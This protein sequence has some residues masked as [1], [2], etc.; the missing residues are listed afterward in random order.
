MRVPQ[1]MGLERFSHVMH[2]TSIVEGQAGRRS[3]S[4]RRARVVLPGGHR[5]G[6]AEGARDADHPRAR[7]DAARALRRRG[8]LSRLRRQPRFLHRDPHGHHV[9]AARRYVQAG[10]G[11][12]IDSNP[13]AEYEET[14]DK[15]RALLRALEL[16]QQGYKIA[17]FRLLSPGDWRTAPGPAIPFDRQSNRPFNRLFN[18]QSNLQYT[19]ISSL[20]NLKFPYNPSG[21]QSTTRSPTTSSSTSAELPAGPTG[22]GGVGTPLALGFP[23]Q[24][25][26]FRGDRE[27]GQAREVDRHRRRQA[28]RVRNHAGRAQGRQRHRPR[29]STPRRPRSRSPASRSTRSVTSSSAT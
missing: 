25:Q 23:A 12:V 26:S 29:A 14:R 8:R 2:L 27:H 24:S 21:R 17:D 7:A 20:P 9:G 15:A 19:E 4:A 5:V 6:R 10:A 22:R 28:H 11:I 1:F 18:L 16:A 13:T 3:R